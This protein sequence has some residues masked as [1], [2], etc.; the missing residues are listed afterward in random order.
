MHAHDPSCHLLEK[1]TN[2]VGLTILVRLIRGTYWYA[3]QVQLEFWSLALTLHKIHH[4]LAANRPAGVTAY[5]L[6][7]FEGLYSIRRL[8][9]SDDNFG[10][11]VVARMF[12]CRTAKITQSFEYTSSCQV[13]CWSVEDKPT[14]FRIRN[15]N[16]AN[17][18][19][20]VSIRKK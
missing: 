8:R 17:T 20:F 14:A 13:Y 10:W 6:R 1:I 16:T 12:P 19:H 11:K 15:Y 5:H 2:S 9:E 3:R 4:L 18:S 7:A